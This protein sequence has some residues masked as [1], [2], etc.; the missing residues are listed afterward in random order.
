MSEPLSREELDF[1]AR[2]ARLPEGK[3]YLRYLEA[4]LGTAD[5][6]LRIAP[7]D[8]VFVAQGRSRAFHELV[9]DITEAEKRL[10]RLSVSRPRVVNHSQT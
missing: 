4:K 1:L 2:F 9:L 6:D 3:M 5:A 7:H 8:S 10:E